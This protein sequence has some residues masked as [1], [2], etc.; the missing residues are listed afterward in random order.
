M[1]ETA[2]RNIFIVIYCMQQSGIHWFCGVL[3]KRDTG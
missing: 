2:H 3:A 1:E